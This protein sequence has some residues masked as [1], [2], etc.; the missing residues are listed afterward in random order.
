MS[1]SLACDG[2]SCLSRRLG[3]P[4][5]LEGPA[6]PI[7]PTTPCPSLPGC[8]AAYS[9]QKQGTKPERQQQ[10]QGRLFL[11]LTEWVTVLGPVKAHLAAAPSEWRRGRCLQEAWLV[12]KGQGLRKAGDPSPRSPETHFPPGPPLLVC[13]IL[14]PHVA[15]SSLVTPPVCGTL[16]QPRSGPSAPGGAPIL[17][18]AAGMSFLKTP[19]MAGLLLCMPCL[20]AGAEAQISPG[21]QSPQ[22]SGPASQLPQ[23]CSGAGGAGQGQGWGRY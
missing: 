18:S 22:G 8:R 6:H 7:P 14:L 17:S 9:A 13:S 4:A 1:S 11:G 20:C 15:C 12:W 10:Q 2:N 5:A 19:S 3:P 23:G 21:T 16:A